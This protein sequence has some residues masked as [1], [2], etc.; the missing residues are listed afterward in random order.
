ML[1]KNQ[2]RSFRQ[3]G[4]LTK[5]AM[6]R[7]SERDW[8]LEMKSNRN[9]LAN[10]HQHKNQ[11][12]GMRVKESREM[13]TNDAKPIYYDA[14]IDA[15]VLLTSFLL[16]F[17]MLVCGGRKKCEFDRNAMNFRL[18]HQ[19][20]V[21]SVCVTF[22]T[23]GSDLKMQIVSFA[24]VGYNFF[25]SLSFSLAFSFSFV[26]KICWSFLASQY[27]SNES[28]NQFTWFDLICDLLFQKGTDRGWKIASKLPPL[29]DAGG[30]WTRI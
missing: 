22:T 12:D 26:L 21:W 29:F 2:K 1:C 25:R 5:L 17:D 4:I 6:F 23:H 28:Q 19:K 15:L 3:T 9:Y 10:F 14:N 20:V 27:N 7:E 30:I 16:A 8:N 11:I 13:R 18:F 24:E